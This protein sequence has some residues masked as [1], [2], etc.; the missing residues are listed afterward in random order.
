LFDVYGFYPANIVKK[1]ECCIILFKK[2]FFSSKKNL[3]K[4]ENG[5]QNG[6]NRSFFRTFARQKL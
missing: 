5:K 6:E 2:I 4:R 3:T 1:N